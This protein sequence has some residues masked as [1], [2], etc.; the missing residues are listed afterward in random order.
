MRWI[1]C[2][3]RR[4]RPMSRDAMLAMLAEAVTR[5]VLRPLDL[6]FARFIAECDPAAEPSLLLMAALASR[7]LSDG[8][9]CLDLHA[10]DVLAAEQEWPG[11]W[12]ELLST[13]STPT[14]RLLAHAEG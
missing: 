11:S 1:A 3:R 10:L 7:Q 4:H 2:S 6:A 8:H 13:A 14:S 9:P 5:R 12:L